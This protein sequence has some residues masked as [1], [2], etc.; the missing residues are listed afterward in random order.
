MRV[1]LAFQRADPTRGAY[2]SVFPV[3]RGAAREVGLDRKEH[4]KCD[5]TYVGQLCIYDSNSAS[6]LAMRCGTVRYMESL[7]L[8]FLL[9]CLLLCVFLVSDQSKSH[10]Y[11]CKHTPLS[12]L[13][14]DVDLAL[15]SKKSTCP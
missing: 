6:S 8:A 10:F 3:R 5:G 4:L 9:L 12:V 13:V 7:T 15:L 1:R 14:R 2:C 11:Q